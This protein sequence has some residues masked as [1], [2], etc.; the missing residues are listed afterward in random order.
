MAHEI[1]TRR[2]D[3]D[4]FGALVGQH[5]GCDGPSDHRREIQYSNAV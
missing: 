5:H 2:F 4:H 3:L 1:A